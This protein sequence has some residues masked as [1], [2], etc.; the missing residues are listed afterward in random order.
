[1]TSRTPRT[2]VCALIAASL[3]FSSLSFAQGRD[4]GDNDR[5]GQHQRGDRADRGDRDGRGDDRRGYQRGDNDRRGDHRGDRGYD[6]RADHYHY[7]ARGPEW[8]RGGHVPHQYRHRQYVVNDWRGHH[9]H[10]PPRGHQWV[11][12]GGDYVLMAIATGLIV[13]LMLAQ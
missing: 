8:R 12:V 10:A 3:G 11:Q 13:N 7:G 4:R 2:I 6:R 9:L 5:Q 1:M